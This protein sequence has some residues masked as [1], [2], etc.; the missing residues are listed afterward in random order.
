M[1]GARK[2]QDRVVRSASG[3]MGWAYVGGLRRS[4]DRSQGMLNLPCIRIP[5]AT[6]IPVEEAVRVE[7]EAIT[8]RD[9]LKNN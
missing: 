7:L 9:G 8:W 4:S 1:E 5:G 6:V 2:F 3:R